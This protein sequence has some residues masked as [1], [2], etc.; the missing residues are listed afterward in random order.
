MITD[1]THTALLIH[2]LENVVGSFMHL[3]LASDNLLEDV[4]MMRDRVW[5]LILN[6]GVP[7]AMLLLLML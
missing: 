3:C 2:D 6:R 4:E 1:L 7:K 5:R